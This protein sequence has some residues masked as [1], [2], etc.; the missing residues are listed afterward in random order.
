MTAKSK[1]QANRDDWTGETCQIE[2]DE[3]SNTFTIGMDDLTF[4]MDRSTRDLGDGCVCVAHRVICIEND[5]W[6][7]VGFENDGI[8]SFR[9]LGV[10]RSHANPFVAFAQL[11]W[12]II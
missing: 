6:Q 2:I 5:E 7:W 4:W 12:N 1:I 9:A 3:E 11:A 8:V 10:E